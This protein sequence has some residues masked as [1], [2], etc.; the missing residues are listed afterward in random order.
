MN[1]VRMEQLLAGR[2]GFCHVLSTQRWL[3]DAAFCDEIVNARYRRRV[4]CRVVYQ[5]V[6]RRVR[7]DTHDPVVVRR[8]DEMVIICFEPEW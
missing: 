5:H 3:K 6:R 2:S 1:P 4:E 7:K 8:F